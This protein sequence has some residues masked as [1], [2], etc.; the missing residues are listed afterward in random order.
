MSQDHKIIPDDKSLNKDAKEYV[1][2]KHRT[3]KEESQLKPKR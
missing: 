3:Q 1:P 2:T